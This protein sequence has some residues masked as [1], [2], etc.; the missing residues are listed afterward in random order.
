MQPP[1]AGSGGLLDP[2]SEGPGALFYGGI[3]AGLTMIAGAL[4][5]GFVI[6]RRTR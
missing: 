4:L 3:A 1:V 5:G 2:E 6:V